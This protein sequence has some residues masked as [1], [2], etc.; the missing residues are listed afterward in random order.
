MQGRLLM[1]KRIFIFCIF[2]VVL[3]F[4]INIKK[5]IENQKKFLNEQTEILQK[6]TEVLE[7]ILET[8]KNIEEG[9]EK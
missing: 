9:Y 3:T 1:K 2:C 6:Q 4:F 5:N 8:I 7:N